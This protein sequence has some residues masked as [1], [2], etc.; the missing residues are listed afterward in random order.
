MTQRCITGRAA[1]RDLRP[2]PI[3]APHLRAQAADDD[4]AS[5]R[6]ADGA[7]L[8]ILHSDADL[9]RALSGDDPVE[10]VLS[11][12]LEQLR[13]ESLAPPAMRGVVQNL[14]HRFETGHARFTGRGRPIRMSG[15][16]CTPSRRSRGRG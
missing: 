15:F 13:C 6:A 5:Q 14:R 7:A 9:H 3:H 2:L 10:R 1:C 4:L 8:R 12:M 16:S 11:E